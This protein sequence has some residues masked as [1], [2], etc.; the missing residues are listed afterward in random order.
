MD[1]WCDDLGEEDIAY[2]M[3]LEKGWSSD[4]YGLS[5][6]NKVFDPHTRAKAGR[7]RRL[8]IVNG[9]S[10]HVNIKFLDQCDRLK[11]LV[12]ILPP[13]STHL[14]QPLDCGNFLP[15]ATY[16]GQGINSVLTDSNSKVSMTKQMFFGVFKPAFKK[17]FSESNIRSA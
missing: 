15:L 17:A 4:V 8:L 11:I 12:L 10:S 1:T 16:Y 14:L 7:G 3:S 9:H 6:L 2:F 13:H 5:W